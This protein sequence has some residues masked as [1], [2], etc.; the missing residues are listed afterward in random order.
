MPKRENKKEPREVDI[1]NRQKNH[2]RALEALENSKICEE[3]KELILKFVR[4][5]RLSTNISIAR[6]SK[7]YRYLR[8][9][10]ELLKKPFDK[11]TTEDI[12][13][14]L[15]KIYNRPVKRGETVKEASLWTKKDMTIILK[16][17]YKWLKGCENPKET[18]WIKLIKIENPVLGPDDLL[19]W[20]DVEK[21]SS[22][23][24]NVRDEALVKVL[25]ESGCRIGEILSLRIGNIE[26]RGKGVVIRLRQSKTKRRKILLVRSAGILIRYRNSH[27]HKEDKSYPLWINLQTHEQLNY[28]AAAHIIKRLAKRAKLDKPVNPHTFR[29]SSATY[30]A[31][32]LSPSELK[33]RFGWKQSSKMLDIYLHPDEEEVNKRILEIEGLEKMEKPKEKFKSCYSCGTLNS[34]KAENCCL[35]G[36][37]LDAEKSYLSKRLVWLVD[38]LIKEKGG[39][40]KALNELKVK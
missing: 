33:A 29:K 36:E 18:A 4:Y 24:M 31:K 20:E 28:A 13:E 27:P 40:D 2:K 7:Y 1:H 8:I 3:N 5:K 37:I 15:E 30:Y 25:W 14:L 23:C 12:E 6:Q 9:L 39:Y 32:Y 35:C 22:V 10:A 17:F 16:A 11:A 19:S 26:H 21:L 38:E 34:L